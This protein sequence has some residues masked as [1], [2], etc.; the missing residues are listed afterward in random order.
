MSRRTFAHAQPSAETG[1]SDIN[2][3]IEVPR[4]LVWRSGPQID[5]FVIADPERA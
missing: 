5:P 2:R 4:E 1:E 3:G